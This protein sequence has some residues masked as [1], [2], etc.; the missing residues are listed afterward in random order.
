[1]LLGGEFENEG[2]G[3][4]FAVGFPGVILAHAHAEHVWATCGGV[5]TSLLEGLEGFEVGSEGCPGDAGVVGEEDY[6]GYWDHG[7]GIGHGEEAM[8]GD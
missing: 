2:M 8:M 5:E 4:A 6:V 7:E 3:H 1:M